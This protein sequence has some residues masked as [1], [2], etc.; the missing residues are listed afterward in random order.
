M[1]GG[2]GVDRVATA[3]LVGRRPEEGDARAYVRVFTDPRIDEEAWPADRRTA[4]G[5]RETLAA[6]IAHWERWGF[7]P[8]TVLV[9]SE[10]VGWTGLQHTRVDGR[11][12]VELLWFLD[13]DLW[14]RGYA[15]ELARE[16]VR[17]AFEVLELDDVVAFTTPANTRSQAVM[18][19]LGMAHERDI[20]HGGLPHVLFRL[21]RPGAV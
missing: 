2:L 12:E 15:P 7:G 10:P 8:W 20:V 3:R 11:P 19:R 9:G 5:A 1:P 14:G 18:R 17:V 13:G 6:F 4:D 21:T 16:A